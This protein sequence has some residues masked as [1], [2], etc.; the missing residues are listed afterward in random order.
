[1]TGIYHSDR[2]DLIVEALI[3]LKRASQTQIERWLIKN[4]ETKH[5]VGDSQATK[6]GINSWVGTYLN[7]LRKKG[8]IEEDG[9][10]T[11]IQKGHRPGK[12]WKMVDGVCPYCGRTP[13]A[14]KRALDRL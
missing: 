4:P 3:E 13:P 14:R 6:E 9:F 12:M 7:R 1:M 11:D 5:L 2:T 8:V 10:T